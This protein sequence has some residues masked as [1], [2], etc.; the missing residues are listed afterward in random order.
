MGNICLN[1]I[2]AFAEEMSIQIA[3]KEVSEQDWV[4]SDFYV[5]EAG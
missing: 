3:R 2:T 4:V 5:Q 1:D